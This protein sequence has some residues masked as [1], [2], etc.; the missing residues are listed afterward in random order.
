MCPR[1][2]PWNRLL[3]SAA[4]LWLHVPHTAAQSLVQLTE[5]AMTHD[6]A[7]QATRAALDAAIHR[8]EQARA[9]LLPSVGLQASTQYSD[10][11]VHGHFAGSPQQLGAQ[12]HS[13]GIQATQALYRPAQLVTAQQ[14]QRQVELAQAQMELA[15]QHLLLRTAQAYFDVLAAQDTL[16]V[17]LAQKQAVMEQHAF[18][19]RNFEN[20]TATITD[21][22]EAQARL[23][24][25]QAQQIAAENTLRIQ[26]LALERLTGQPNAQPWTVLQQ[27][28]P[29]S[30]LLP[31]TLPDATAW[32]DLAQTRHPQLAQASLAV[33][34]A[35]LENVKARTGHLPTVD[36]Q[37]SL[38]YQRTPNGTSTIPYDSRSHVG[39]VGV[40]LNFPIFTGFSVQNRIRETISLEEKAQA[41]LEDTRRQ[42]AQIA[43]AA[44]YDL[45]S[46][47]QQVQALEAA[48]ASSLSAL[49]ANQLGYSVGVR[50]NM[51]VLN[52]QS[53]WFQA[54]KDLLQ[55]RYQILLGLLRL[56]QTAGILQMQDVH[57]I[58]T[59]LAPTL[60]APQL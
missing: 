1:N 10:S 26:R 3:L 29:L 6:A 5:E 44:F 38:Q 35:R 52:A 56:R 15:S 55:A 45:Q 13:A 51:D 48:V 32:A 19:Q 42:I 31:H 40:V 24:L 36:L 20:G 39:T 57:D 60:P 7:W 11:R 8:G 17:V 49:Q 27:L 41:E 34:I 43:R 22:H 16:A 18:A 46:A 21:T 37:A 53:Q 25:V 12:Q 47:Q 9:G 59:L 33:D 28:P 58:N 54:Q 50:I 23:D 4:L 14:G 2:V 30:T